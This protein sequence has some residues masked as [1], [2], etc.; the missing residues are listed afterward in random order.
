M[1][2]YSIKML[3]KCCKT[4]ISSSIAHLLMID[5]CF[6]QS[7]PL[8]YFSYNEGLNIGVSFL[9]SCCD[10]VVILCSKIGSKIHAFV[11]QVLV[12]CGRFSVNS[13]KLPN[14]MHL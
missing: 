1:V 6:V 2:T 13:V 10:I 9:H 3:H 7:K 4:K 14:P 8:F 5:H 12:Y 11:V